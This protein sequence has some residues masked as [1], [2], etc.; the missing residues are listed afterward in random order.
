MS[1]WLHSPHPT[2]KLKE[3]NETAVWWPGSQLHIYS[4]SSLLHPPPPLPAPATVDLLPMESNPKPT[5][6]SP[7]QCGFI[8]MIR[9]YFLQVNT[10]TLT[11][12][13]E[14]RLFHSNILLIPDSIPLTMHSRPALWN[15]HPHMWRRFKTHFFPEANYSSLSSS[16]YPPP[17]SCSAINYSL[18][19]KQVKCL[20]TK[21]IVCSLGMGLLSCF[22][23]YPS[24]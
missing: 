13:L 14:W 15:A 8:L 1:F 17:P 16:C 3:L 11:F 12:N 19:D 22:L 2:T 10:Y 24:E 21:Y 23:L 18:I 6:Q 20:A 9:S 4:I 7:H 5:C